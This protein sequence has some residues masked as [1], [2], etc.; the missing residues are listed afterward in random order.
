MSKVHEPKTVRRY[1]H[2]RKKDDLIVIKYGTEWC[3][4]CKAIRPYLDQLSQEYPT[5]YFLD[6][7]IE[8]EGWMLLKDFE[9]WVKGEEVEV[10]NKESTE[11]DGLWEVKIR[12]HTRHI[13]P[14]GLEYGQIFQS[15]DFRGIRSVPTFKIFKEGELVGSFRGADKETIRSSVVEH[16]KIEEKIAIE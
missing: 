1:K 11:G 5:V 8:T 15:D 13:D 12:G 14:S 3:G 4:P 2:Y 10:I 16:S 6:V 9:E 7:D